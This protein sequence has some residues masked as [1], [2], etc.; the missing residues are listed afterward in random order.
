[1]LRA[2]PD[3]KYIVYPSWAQLSYK[4]ADLPRLLANPLES[5]YI[6]PKKD[7]RQLGFPDSV[8]PC[9]FIDGPF[10]GGIIAADRVPGRWMPALVLTK[11]ANLRAP[12]AT[13]NWLDTL[14]FN[15][16]YLEPYDDP[17]LSRLEA[18]QRTRLYLCAVTAENIEADV[19]S[20][21]WVVAFDGMKEPKGLNDLPSWAAGFGLRVS[22]LIKVLLEICNETSDWFRNPNQHFVWYAVE[23][24][25]PLSGYCFAIVLYLAFHLR[26][27]AGARLRSVH[28]LA[29]IEGKPNMRKSWAR[30]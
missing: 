28:M 22:R 7:W 18:K 20:Q 24:F 21:Y 11:E 9:S 23:G 17:L 29:G 27:I 5:G 25:S 6:D 19:D 10:G 13:I 15:V 1:M 30:R 2:E 3:T 14:R 16:S 8:A 26:K 4:W 12:D